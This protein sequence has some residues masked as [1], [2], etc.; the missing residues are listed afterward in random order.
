MSDV[1]IFW[2]PTGLELDSLGTKRLAG[3]SD[4]DTPSITVSIRMLSIDTPETY[5]NPSGKDGLFQELADWMLAGQAPIADDLVAYLQPKLATGTAG[6]LQETQGNLAKTHFKQ[7]LD[8]R[9]TRDNGRKRTLF[10]RTANQPFDRYGRLLAYVSPNYSPEELQ[11]M[12]RHERRTFNLQMVE[13]GWAAPFVIFPS[14]PSYPD[15]VLFQDGA[16]RAYDGHLGAWA[17]PMTLTGYEYRMMV[18]LHDITKKLVGGRKIS[19]SDRYAWIE[20]YCADM[21]TQ[22]IFYPQ[23]YHKILPYNR[24]FV[25][26]DEVGAAVSTLNLTPG[27]L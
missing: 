23:Q 22:E 18:R 27:R 2:D 11:S 9:L 8:L 17:N 15:L 25:W 7:I 12:T 3:V 21:T 6:T 16:K 20:R 24:V 10:I 1:Q 14:I 13:D 26:P 19:G 4:G 5:G